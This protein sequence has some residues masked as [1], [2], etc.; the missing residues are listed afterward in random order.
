VY[1]V[2]KKSTVERKLKQKEEFL[3]DIKKY[4]SL[5]DNYGYEYEY[6]K[7][8]IHALYWVLNKAV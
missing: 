2:R 1:K 7:G 4:I 6:Q 5:I 8:Y 3:K